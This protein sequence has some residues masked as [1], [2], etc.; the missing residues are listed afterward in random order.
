MAKRKKEDLVAQFLTAVLLVLICFTYV[1]TQSVGLTLFNGFCAFVVM[2]IV[3][4]LIQRNKQKE[5]RNSGILHIDQM[6][7]VQFEEYLRILFIATGYK[8]KTTPA[9][10]DFGADL[11]LEKENKRIAVQAKRYKSTVGIK[12]VQEVASAKTHYRANETWVVT[13]SKFTKAAQQLAESNDVKLLDRE[14]L[15][16]LMLHIKNKQITKPVTK[17]TTIKS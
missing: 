1:I 6:S 2:K 13:N 15:I 14:K 11:I 17:A 9:S 10:G 8:V 5:I 4:T 12:A 3:V 16:K 7:G